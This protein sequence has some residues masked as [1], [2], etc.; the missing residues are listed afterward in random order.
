MV[1]T[2][3]AG[4]INGLAVAIA[5]SPAHFGRSGGT[6][7]G[8]QAAPAR[9]LLDDDAAP[10]SEMGGVGMAEDEATPRTPGSRPEQAA[11]GNSR[12]ALVQAMLDSSAYQ[13]GLMQNF[14]RKYLG[15]AATTGE[16]SAMLQAM[17]NGGSWDDVLAQVLT[18]DECF[19]RAGGTTDALLKRLARDLPV[20]T[21]GSTKGGNI[22]A[23]DVLDI[24]RH[25]PRR[26]DEN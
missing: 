19:N 4:G 5:T 2:L 12:L 21:G 18:S 16:V 7:S 25:P 11:R 8:W 26:R 3:E 9:D 6:M 1:N 14:Y 15:R 24:L 20:Q 13:T 10:I 23:G 17:H 22:K